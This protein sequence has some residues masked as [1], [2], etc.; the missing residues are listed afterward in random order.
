VLELSGR[1]DFQELFVTHTALA[2]APDAAL[3]A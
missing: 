1:A 3:A 2:P